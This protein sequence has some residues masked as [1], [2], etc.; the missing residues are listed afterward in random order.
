M[1]A[2]SDTDLQEYA[3]EQLNLVGLY[4]L[5]VGA[6][7]L[8]I[9]MTGV[10]IA[11]QTQKRHQTY[12]ELTRLKRELTAM[13]VEQGRL[14]IEQQTFS[15]TP[16]VA[17]RAASELGMHYPDKKEQIMGDVARHDTHDGMTSPASERM[18]GHHE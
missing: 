2:H 5:M 11:L 8:A 10:M 13:Q 18:G 4:R 1:N 14:L 6:L 15:A 3:T 16:Q 17:R 12:Q 7:L 9:L